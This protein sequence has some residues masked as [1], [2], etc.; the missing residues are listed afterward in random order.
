MLK[1]DQVKAVLEEMFEKDE[2]SLHLITSEQLALDKRLRGVGFRTISNVLGQ[3]RKEHG[4]PTPARNFKKETVLGYLKILEREVPPERF[5]A[6]SVNDLFNS[7]N[8][9]GIG[10]TTISMALADY[11]RLLR[12]R[13]PKRKL[14][15]YAGNTKRE[16]PSVEQESAV[17]FE[18][19]LNNC[20]KNLKRILFVLN[21]NQSELSDLINISSSSLKNIIA[22]KQ[23]PSLTTVLNL[24]FN[25]GVDI[26]AFLFNTGKLFKI[27]KSFQKDEHQT[28]IS[29]IESLNSYVEELKKQLRE[30]KENLES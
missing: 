13:S 17:F 7:P 21:L 12:V 3:F 14:P 11:K 18:Q 22:K 26:N 25:L 20:S 4:L 27:K 28:L 6:L 23:L 30:T 15:K 24:Y 19:I 2:R 9:F 16:P 8:L 1:R 10:R 5:E 29:T